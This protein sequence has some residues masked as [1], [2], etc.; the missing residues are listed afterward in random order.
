[1]WAPAFAPHHPGPC[2]DPKSLSSRQFH[3]W[4]PVAPS[5]PSALARVVPVYPLNLPGVIPLG[6]A[7]G[8]WSLCSK[9]NGIHSQDPSTFSAVISFV[10]VR[11]VESWRDHK[12]F[13]LYSPREVGVLRACICTI[14]RA[15]G[16]SQGV[17][18]QL[19]WVK[20]NHNKLWNFISHFR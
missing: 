1:M 10:C 16:V 11:E 5:S 19:L 3:F 4:K 17:Q 14:K 12:K 15:T 2:I 18:G 20:K 8:F 9:G 7:V 13:T 6:A